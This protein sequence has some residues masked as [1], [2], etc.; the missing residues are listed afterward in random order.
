MS[1]L[2]LPMYCHTPFRLGFPS[3]IRAPLPTVLAVVLAMD[4]TGA[5]GAWAR[6]GASVR[7]TQ[8]TTAAVVERRDSLLRILRSIQSYIRTNPVSIKRNTPRTEPSP[9]SLDGSRPY[10]HHTVLKP[11]LVRRFGREWTSSN[12]GGL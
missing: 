6:P 4:F 12:P 3:G 8:T 2:A 5:A 9:G 10:T 11:A 1:Q 7:E